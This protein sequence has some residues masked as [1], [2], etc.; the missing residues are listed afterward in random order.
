M[1]INQ[2]KKLRKIVRIKKLATKDTKLFVCTMKK[3]SVCCKM[4]LIYPPTIFFHVHTI[5]IPRNDIYAHLCM[6]SF[7]KQFTDDYLST[8]LFGQ[9]ARK[10]FVQH[11]RYY[12]EVFL[13]RVNDGREIINTRVKVAH[14]FNIIVGSIFA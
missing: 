11:P 4:V 14:A 6:Q 3:T 12:I 2:V 9:E 13:K 7:P 8:H 1:I 5:S 10:V